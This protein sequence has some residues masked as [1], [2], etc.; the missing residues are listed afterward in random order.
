MDGNPTA[1]SPFVYLAPSGSYSNHSGVLPLAILIEPCARWHGTATRAGQ[2]VS[3]ACR[4]MADMRASNVPAQLHTLFAHLNSAERQRAQ[5]WGERRSWTPSPG[6]GIT[7]LAQA[8]SDVF[9]AQLPPGQLLIRQGAQI[10]AFPPTV[11]RPGP[12]L[13]DEHEPAPLG[14]G[15]EALPRLLHTRVADGDV[16]MLA[17]S[18][19]LR[20][21]PR[22]ARELSLA[23]LDALVTNI[24]A[25]ADHAR[26]RDGVVGIMRLA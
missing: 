10:Y 22:A 17:S 3:I 26:L 1:S 7:C 18:T 9:I 2:L 19:M 15:A 4:F 14:R 5:E 16:I 8:G 21:A 11:E 20:F 12:A 24:G 23:S 13:G 6:F 25:A